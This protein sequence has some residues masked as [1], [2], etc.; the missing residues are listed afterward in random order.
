[1][2]TN[3]RLKENYAK[4]IDILTLVPSQASGNHSK[5]TFI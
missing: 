1:M 2:Y 4:F 3:A 5:L